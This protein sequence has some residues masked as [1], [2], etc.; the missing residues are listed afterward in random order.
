MKVGMADLE[1]HSSVYIGTLIRVSLILMFFRQQNC[2][3]R[4]DRPAAP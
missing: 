3:S 4:G 1:K 2:G